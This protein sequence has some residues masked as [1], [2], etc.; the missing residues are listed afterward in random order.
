M[1][2]TMITP[3]LSE[4]FRSS[5][6]DTIQV[7]IS[8]AV[9]NGSR[10]ITIP[11]YNA[12]CDRDEWRISVSIK[13]PDDF[14]LI[15][16]NCF[17]V[18]ETGVYDNMITNSRSWDKETITKAEGE[19]RNIT[20][21]GKG[22][23]ILDGGKHNR[24]LE[25]TNRKYGLPTVWRNTL[26]YWL[27]VSNLHVENIR[28]QNQRYWSMTHMFC[29]HVKLKNLDFY[30]VPHVCNL[31]GINLRQGCHH[32]EIENITGRTGDDT[33]A[34]TALSSLH[35]NEWFV[36]G[37]SPDIHDVKIRNVKSDSYTC[38]MLRLL[39]HDGRKIYNIDVD[40]LMEASDYA[41]W[42][43]RNGGVVCIGSPLYFKIRQAYEGETS[44]IVMRNI[45]SRSAIAVTLNH[46]VQDTLFSN[47]KVFGDGL[48]GFGT[49]TETAEAGKLHNVTIEHFLYSPIQQEIRLSKALTKDKYIGTVFDLDTLAGDLKLK[50]VH[51]DRVGTAFKCFGDIKIDAEDFSCNEAGR[52]AL[53]GKKTVLTID[54][55]VKDDE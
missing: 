38:Y 45:T 15:L 33:V 31:D 32:F 14:T 10:T 5:D 53:L 37:K 16:D 24:L 39:N 43:R 30:A 17:M 25:K 22:N 54:G 12:R 46:T 19:Q 51:I 49:W 20:V 21:I 36:E 3:N 34:L 27:N 11:R 48:V 6:S 23:V 2:G 4:C 40:T 18:M 44:N 35:E 26:L 52:F 50:D 29:D 47:V 41:T 9:E 42:K 1:P 13:V 28:I 8:L 55:E 7:A